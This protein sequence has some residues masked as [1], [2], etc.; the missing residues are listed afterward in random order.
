MPKK[1]D[2]TGQRFGRWTVLYEAEPKKSPSGKS[3]YTMWHCRCDCGKEKDVDGGN[4]VSGISKSCGCGNIEDYIGKKF[5]M[6]T[7][8]GWGNP[9]SVYSNNPNW[10]AK[11]WRCKCECGNIVDVYPSE[12]KANRRQSCGCLKAINASKRMRAKNH[13]TY[14]I[15]TYDYG[16]GYTNKGEQFKFDKEDLKLLKEYCW[17]INNSGYLSAKIC[18]TDNHVSMHN[19]VMGNKYIDHING[20][21][22]DNRKCNL[23]FGGTEYSFDSY[24]QMNKGLQ[25]NN[26]SGY[27]GV[28]W[29]KRDNVWEVHI[30]RG[31]KLYY[32]GRFTDYNDAVNARKKAEDNFFGEY[33]YRNSQ[34]I[35]KQEGMI[36]GIQKKCG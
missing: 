5:G 12:L 36:N 16:V 14:D 17:F 1:K 11:T 25:S 3:R 9:R 22:T 10:I 15:D 4:L 6:L 18:G 32:V 34:T 20:D 19:L 27:P 33:A 2:L 31:N 30:S 13:N 21:K 23:R 26:K 24:N 35:S 29:H 8:L 7:V 28:S